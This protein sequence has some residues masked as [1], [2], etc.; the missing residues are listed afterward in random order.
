[1]IHRYGHDFTEIELV[2]DTHGDGQYH[3]FDGH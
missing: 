3:V 2:H 1:L